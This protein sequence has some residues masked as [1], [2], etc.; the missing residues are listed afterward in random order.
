MPT[1]IHPAHI[2]TTESRLFCCGVAKKFN[3]VADTEA[4]LSW[5]VTVFA[6]DRK[7]ER[8]DAGTRPGPVHQRQSE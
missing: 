5:V 4:A 8:E 7:H 1:E 2:S 3:T 6:I